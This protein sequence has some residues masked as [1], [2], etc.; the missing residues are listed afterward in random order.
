MVNEILA[1]HPLD[2]LMDKTCA[3]GQE[4]EMEITQLLMH[5][6]CFKN[7]NNGTDYDKDY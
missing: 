1:L 4:L 7:D 5:M 3:S 6:L 2:T